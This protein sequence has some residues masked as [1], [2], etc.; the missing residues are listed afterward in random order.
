MGSESIFRRIFK[1]VNARQEIRTAILTRK[2]KHWLM[3]ARHPSAYLGCTAPRA[4]KNFWRLIAKHP[5]IAAG[6]HLN[7]AS[8][9]QPY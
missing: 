3:V 7:A 8:V 2:M 9:Y 4:R 5:E 6:L 1:K